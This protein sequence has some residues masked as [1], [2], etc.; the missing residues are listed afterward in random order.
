VAIVASTLTAALV[1]GA[2]WALQ[3]PVDGS[4]VIHACYAP[5]TGVVKLNVTGSCASGQIAISWNQTGVQGPQGAQGATGATGATGPQGIAGP[6]GPAPDQYETQNAW[7]QTVTSANNQTPI[8][9][10]LDI[11]AGD[12]L[13]LTS[14]TWNLNS[15]QCTISASVGSHAVQYNFLTSFQLT[16]I[17]WYVDGSPTPSITCGGVSNV[18]LVGYLTTLP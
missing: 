10:S 11:P 3:S 12:R 2:A 5:S 8:A 18:T 17:N 15:G 14:I 1:G 4:G 6:A 16:A 9:Q 13:T 7:T